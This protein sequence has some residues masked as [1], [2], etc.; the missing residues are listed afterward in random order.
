MEK[1]LIKKLDGINSKLEDLVQT[2]CVDAL[3][4]LRTLQQEKDLLEKELNEFQNGKDY[5]T[6]VKAYQESIIR[7]NEEIKALKEEIFSLKRRI[8]NT[9]DLD[10]RERVKREDEKKELKTEIESLRIEI[11]DLRKRESTIQ[12]LSERLHSMKEE[13]RV[14]RKENAS[15]KEA[16]TDSEK[17]IELLKQNKALKEE[18]SILKDILND[19]E[20]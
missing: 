18:I 3:G 13:V 12:V 19:P 14:L 2:V 16:K 7:K 15:L 9:I 4:R 20:K 17:V 6:T 10:I 11:E 8:N 1:E 5:K